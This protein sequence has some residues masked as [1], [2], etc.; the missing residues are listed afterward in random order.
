MSTFQ[1]AQN[2]SKITQKSS[3]TAL[4][5]KI[6][7]ACGAL[8]GAS[9]RGPC[10]TAQNRLPWAS[11]SYPSP[12]TTRRN[13]GPAAGR[14]CCTANLTAELRE[15]LNGMPLTSVGA[16]TMFARVKRRADRGGVSRH[17]TRMGAVLC[18]RD[19]TVAMGAWEGGPGWPPQHGAQAL[20]P[21][22]GQPHDGRRGRTQ[23]RRNSIRD[24][25]S[26]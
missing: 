14:V 6:F 5:P 19:K 15:R 24:K 7:L 3:K 1:A 16:E 11:P 26:D 4:G 10:L 23:G 25:S 9:P 8:K 22:L 21:W 13:P 2:R 20:A 17:D 12:P 18:D